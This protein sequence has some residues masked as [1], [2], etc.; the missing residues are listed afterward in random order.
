[1]E[2]ESDFDAS[3]TLSSIFKPVA[4]VLCRYHIVS[5][6]MLCFTGKN[7]QIAS[8]GLFGS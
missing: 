5:R 4:I 3:G 8:L 6:K 7:I 1:M 2:P